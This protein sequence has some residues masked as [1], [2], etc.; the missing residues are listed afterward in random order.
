MSVVRGRP[1]AFAGGMSGSIKRYWSSLSAC[2]EPKS[3]TS[4]RSSG[5]HIGS[6]QQGCTMRTV[7]SHIHRR[8]STAYSDLSKRAV[9][10]PA[11]PHT[12][13]DY[14]ATTPDDVARRAADADIIVTNKVAINGKALEQL[15]RLKLIAVAATGVDRIDLDA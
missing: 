6:L 4:A 10:S 12:W 15:P 13:R 9:R 1:P 5:V 8:P 2:P 14:A 7:T 11:F 3:P